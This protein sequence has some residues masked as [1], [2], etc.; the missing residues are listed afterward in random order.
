MLRS[1]VLRG[2]REHI[3]VMESE[4]GVVEGRGWIEGLSMAVRVGLTRK[5]EESFE[6]NR[7]IWR[8]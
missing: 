4:E 6:G 5:A 8:T 1:R 3:E 2:K 7:Y